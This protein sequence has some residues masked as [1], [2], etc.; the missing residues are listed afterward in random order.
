M[1][2]S[3]QSNLTGE[4]GGDKNIKL[5]QK[6]FLSLFWNKKV[7]FCE[8]LLILGLILVEKSASRTNAATSFILI[9]ST[10]SLCCGSSQS[11][12]IY[13]PLTA[14]NA[15]KNICHL[16][17]KNIIRCSN[18]FF[19][20]SAQRKRKVFFRLKKCQSWEDLV[21]RADALAS[22]HQRGLSPPRGEN[23][24]K[25]VSSCQDHLGRHNQF[26]KL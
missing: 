1:N 11:A 6:H 22:S 16:S 26:T 14:S 8:K 24:S 21:C 3:K 19:K 15:N 9:L 17:G 4:R 23:A 5:G 7:T 25:M 12:T 2:Q 13:N 10:F 20:T 18:I